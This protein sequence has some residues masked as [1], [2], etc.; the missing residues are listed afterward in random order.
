MDKV[1]DYAHVI[2]SALAALGILGWLREWLKQ[3]AREG[4][5]GELLERLHLDRLI[6]TIFDRLVRW[7][8]AREAL[9]EPGGQLRAEMVKA[10]AK[11]EL[12]RYGVE[13]NDEEADVRTESA[14][15][16]LQHAESL[17][18]KNGHSPALAS[19]GRGASSE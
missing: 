16:R 19:S 9:G 1:L 2:V 17:A 18:S 11:D 10:R 6:D 15:L 3:K 5:H 14:Y 7:G 12:T 4:R 13:L 8:Q